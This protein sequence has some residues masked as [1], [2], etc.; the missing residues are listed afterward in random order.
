MPLHLPWSGSAAECRQAR[1][2]REGGLGAMHAA[3]AQ[4]SASHSD[5][6]FT[7][8]TFVFVYL[9]ASVT[10]QSLRRPRVARNLFTARLLS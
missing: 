6:L 8:L 2:Y 9:L 5:A 10:L 3:P 4:V 7:I 1:L